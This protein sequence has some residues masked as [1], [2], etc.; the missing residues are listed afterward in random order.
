MSSATPKEE[1]K[2]CLLSSHPIFL[3][4]LTKLIGNDFQV[5]QAK[6]E[7]ADTFQRDADCYVVDGSASESAAESKI[8]RILVADPEKP[9]IVVLDGIDETTVFP[10]LELG[11]KGVLGYEHIADQIARAIVAVTEGG[12]WVPRTILSSFLNVVLRRKRAQVQKQ[13]AAPKPS[14]REEEILE[15]ILANCSNKEIG[16]KLNISERTVKFHVSN[17]LAKYHVQR[18]AD[19]MLLFYQRSSPPG[20]RKK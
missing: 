17:L 5:F 18:R 10:L 20:L 16:N 6:G 3:Q 7:L 9:I 19:L 14:K 15:G 1:M 8:A 4:Q 13:K 2:V 12:F 11:V